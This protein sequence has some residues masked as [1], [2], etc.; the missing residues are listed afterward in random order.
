MASHSPSLCLR[1]IAKAGLQHAPASTEQQTASTSSEPDDAAPLSESAQHAFAASAQ[2]HSLARN[3]H[4]QCQQRCWNRRHR[5]EFRS[6]RP[7]A[8]SPCPSLASADA[9]QAVQQNEAP[10]SSAARRADE[11][12]APQPRSVQSARRLPCERSAAAFAQQQAGRYGYGSHQKY[13]REYDHHQAPAHQPSSAAQIRSVL[14]LAPPQAHDRTF[15]A[16]GYADQRPRLGRD[17]QVPPSRP[18]QRF[19]ASSASCRR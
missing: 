19:S 7:T 9:S 15:S 1:T 12:H 6:H 18:Q 5:P 4:D 11:D 13:G 10:Q 14:A 16:S 17:A 2:V 8:A 3:H